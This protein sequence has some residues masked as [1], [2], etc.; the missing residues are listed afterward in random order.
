MCAMDYVKTCSKCHQ[1]KKLHKTKSYSFWVTY[2]FCLIED[3]QIPNF[4]IANLETL[5]FSGILM[6]QL[7]DMPIGLHGCVV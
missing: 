5:P 4:Y 3:N 7:F 1:I 6:S 2:K